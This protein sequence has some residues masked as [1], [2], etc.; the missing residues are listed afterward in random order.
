M[1]KYKTLMAMGCIT[2]IEMFALYNG[3]DG[4]LLTLSVGA[5]AGLGGY[6]LRGGG[7]PSSPSAS[8]GQQ[9]KACPE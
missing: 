2:I 9:A 7:P 6:E 3:I 1:S 8:G 5:L 4:A